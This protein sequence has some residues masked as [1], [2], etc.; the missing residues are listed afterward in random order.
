MK[1]ISPGQALASLCLF[2]SLLTGASA[3]DANVVSMGDNTFSLSRQAGSAFNRDTDA[4]KAKVK[5]DAAKY[6][7]AQ[8]KE[9]K[10][11]SLTSERPLPT[12]GYAN[13]KIVF[14]A[15]AAGDPELTRQ[16][17][18][19]PMISVGG[20]QVQAAAGGD[21]YSELI[22]LDDLHKKGILTDDEFQAEKKKILKRHK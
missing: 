2:L 6:C 9:M 16:P 18:P 13:A 14:M 11:I 5:A 22:K 1:T 10:V 7:A 15:L 21:M 3:A 17:D 19:V 8:G 12:L 4:L 20:T